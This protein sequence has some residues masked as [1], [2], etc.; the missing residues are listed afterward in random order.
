MRLTALFPIL[1]L[2]ACLAPNS[3]PNWQG[4][5]PGA[6]ASAPA[7]PMTASSAPASPA[8][9]VTPCGP[10]CAVVDG[11]IHVDVATPERACAGDTIQ[12]AFSNLNQA[13]GVAAGDRVTLL[14]VR[15]PAAVSAPRSI[16]DKG[17]PPNLAGGYALVALPIGADGKAVGSLKL[18]GSYGPT[19]SGE[20]FSLTPGAQLDLWLQTGAGA[21]QALPISLCPAS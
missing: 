16:G 4:P 17:L 11:T 10:G 5:S 8:P 18:A 21:A 19:A 12:V 9:V 14:L 3:D 1:L 15:R 6:S 7:S 13:L 20:T 2:S